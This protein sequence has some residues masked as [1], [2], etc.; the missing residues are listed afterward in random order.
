[1][2]NYKVEKADTR[3]KYEGLRDL[4]VRVFGDE[5]AFVDHVY[6]LFG[7]E[8]DPAGKTFGTGAE[9]ADIA[10][11]VICNEAG[12]VVSA[13]T[14][15]KAGTFVEPES[16]TA[17]NSAQTLSTGEHGA[18]RPV[19]V[20]YAVCTD[21]EYRGL[22]LG[23]QLTEYVKN[24]VTAAPG[25][26]ISLVSPAE[27][28]LIDFYRKLGYGE[29][30]FARE[31][32]AFAESDEEVFPIEI[33][34]DTDEDDGPPVIIEYEVEAV[35]VSTYNMYRERFLEGV[36]HVAMSPAMLELVKSVS[37][38]GDGMLVVNG[39]DAI[40]VVSEA[41]EPGD[42]EFDAKEIGD[43]AYGAEELGVK[44]ISDE[45]RG[46]EVAERS[47]RPLML[48]ELLVSPA[49]LALSEEIAGEI[50]S[51]LAKRFG[52]EKIIYRMPADGGC[53]L[54]STG[55]GCQSMTAGAGGAEFYFGFP[56]E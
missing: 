41:P 12:R 22:G 35:D 40:C 10:G 19:Y 32:E 21:P 56:V 11:Y 15:Y 17:D 20:S 24:V 13:L 34:W 45:A 46:A 6:R 52:L 3:A 9:S 48:N 43:E 50:A 23:G 51:G 29:T 49:L 2:T 36:P 5:P 33:D 8:P 18:G 55:G 39:G 27:E 37:L 47:G 4:W 54:I 14:C 25:G 16:M 28:S 53:Q 30:C 7:A 42:E 38:G 31:Q 1:M 26:G 44:E